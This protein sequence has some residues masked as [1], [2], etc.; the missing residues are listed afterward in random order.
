MEQRRLLFAGFLSRLPLFSGHLYKYRHFGRQIVDREDERSSI[1]HFH[2]HPLTPPQIQSNNFI[3]LQ[4]S[5]FKVEVPTMFHFIHGIHSIG[6]GC[7]TLQFDGQ[8]NSTTEV[9][10]IVVRIILTS[11]V[12]L[13]SYFI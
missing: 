2:C 13:N 1:Y 4:F 11:N 3:M 9:H 5:G 6:N 8:T 10:D 7:N 12:S